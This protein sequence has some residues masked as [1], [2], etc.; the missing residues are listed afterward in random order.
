MTMGKRAPLVLPA[1]EG[2]DLW[3]EVYDTDGNP[4]ML[5]EEPHVVRLLGDVRDLAVLDVA[6][7]TG[8]HT[9][10]L[11]HAGADVIGIDFSEGMLAKARTKAGAS[12]ARFM[13]HDVAAPLPFAH[14][15]FDRVLCALALDHVADLHMFF[16]ELRRVCGRAGFIVASVMHPAMMLKGV[17]ARFHDASTGREIR[18]ES[19]PHQVSDYVMA[20]TRSGLRIDELTEHAAD[21]SLATRAPRAGRYVGWPMLLMMRLSRTPG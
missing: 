9:L 10:R 2:Y 13:H 15:R 3:S 11:A 7:G 6:C 18:P 14:E 19:C 17:Q 1:S 12:G 16:S 21:A 4:L 20:A 8:R 5:L